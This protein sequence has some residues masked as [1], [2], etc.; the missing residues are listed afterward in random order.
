M[1]S[2]KVE[3]LVRQVVKGEVVALYVSEDLEL[4]FVPSVGM[5]F[6][7]GTSTW[8]W[9]I[10]GGELMPKIEAVICDL[11]QETLVCLFTVEKSLKSGFWTKIEGADIEK[12][13]YP[14]YY[15]ARS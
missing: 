15:Q 11:D 9:E 2:Y 14:A 7:Q 3:L 10:E 6:K 4:P 13:T 1:N 12:S 5:Q 8:L